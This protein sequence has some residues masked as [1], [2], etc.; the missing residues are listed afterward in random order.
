MN[1]YVNI[2]KEYADAIIEFLIGEA[3][4]VTVVGIY[5]YFNSLLSINKLF[6]ANG[7]L[8]N[9]SNKVEYNC[10]FNTYKH[11][12]DTI[13]ANIA[14]EGAIV[15]LVIKSDDKISELGGI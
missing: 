5:K 4:E 11:S 10:I 9:V 15:G 14:I 7:S 1:G 3:H 13:I 6:V 12:N 2:A 8:N